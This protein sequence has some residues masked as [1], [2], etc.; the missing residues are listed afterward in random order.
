M[1]DTEWVYSLYVQANPIP[2]PERFLASQYDTDLFVIEGSQD[3][4]TQQQLTEVTANEPASLRRVAAIAFAAVIVVG[5]IVAGVTLLAG[6]E[7]GVASGGGDTPVGVETEAT[8]SNVHEVTFDGT[9]CTYLGPSEVAPGNHSFILTDLTNGAIYPFF[10]VRV[11]SDGHTYQDVV[12]EQ[13]ERGG[14]G[15]VFPRA[16]WVLDAEVSADLPDVDLADNQRLFS[17][18]YTLEPGSHEVIMWSGTD[19]L[20]LCGPLEVVEP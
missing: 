13:N 7:S 16:D 18:S 20:G 6:D 14:P 11:L 12:D 15:T 2:D 5:V 19:W 17:A 10:A 9:T 8:I 4:D 3:M 1:S